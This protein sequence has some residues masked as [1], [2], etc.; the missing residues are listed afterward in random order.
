MEWLPSEQRPNL[1]Q[2]SMITCDTWQERYDFLGG[3]V[4]LCRHEAVMN[5]VLE[6]EP[7]TTST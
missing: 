1:F 4:Y 7:A 2:E 6:R 3:T 5:R